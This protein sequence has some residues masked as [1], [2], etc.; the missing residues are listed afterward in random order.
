MKYE[1]HSY[2]E[3]ATNWI[4]NKDKVGLL[5]DMG[6]G[7][8][9]C[10]LT[11]IEEL[12]Y[13]YF[14]IVKALV[15]APLRVAEDTW[16]VEAEKWNHL[17]NLKISKI[18][19][20]EKE[21][22]AALNI[23]ADIYVINRENVVWLVKECG[24]NWP[25]DMVV[26]DELSSFKS[27]KSQ[28]F[29]A[30]RKIR[31]KRIVGLT[32]TPSPNGLMDLWSEIYLLDQ[33]ERLGKTLTSYRDQYFVPDK[34][35]QNIIFSYKP[36]EEAEDVIYKKL[37]DICISMKAED[38][39]ELPERIDNII[40]VKLQKDVEEKYKK[41]EKELLLPLKDSD[42]VANN[43]AVLTNKLLQ[44]AN[45][46]I[47]D[48][49]DEVVEIHNEKLKA[50]EEIIEAASGKPVL[51]F[52]AYKHDR[53]RLKKYFKN[54]KELK[55]SED[56]KKWNNGE[57]EIMLVHPASAGHGLNLQAGGNIIIWFGLTWSL[58][59]YQ[60]ANA[61]VYRQGQKQNVIIHHLVAK[62]T[63]DE[64]VMRALENKS[65]GQ[66]V[67]LQA[68]KARIGGKTYD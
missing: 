39:L 21:R 22:R 38:Y 41:F 18:L 31:A 3:Y 13:N 44:F 16:T 50:L 56:I 61:R 15:I 29:K 26:V 32:G 4:L 24:K 6:L 54:A 34:R 23:K 28:R 47:Y 7:K 30:L 10:T 55:T 36:K 49:N 33:G 43:A 9:V 42:I 35:N 25:F 20:T 12:I 52:Y 66:E 60:Q 58:E 14:D 17:K 8:T 51:I 59:L 11:A 67:L 53:D 37:S 2:Q 5:M 45:G 62:G 46:A 63:I 1:P 65:V 19:G 27:P 57:I 68:V 64:N 40:S 48:E